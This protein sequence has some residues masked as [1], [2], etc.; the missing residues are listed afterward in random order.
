LKIGKAG[1]N[2]INLLQAGLGSFK[3]DIVLASLAENK[4]SD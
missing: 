1:N 3:K 2:T 4:R